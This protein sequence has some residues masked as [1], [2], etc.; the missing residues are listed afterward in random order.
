MVVIVHGF[1][2]KINALQFEWSWQNPK[3]SKRLIFAFV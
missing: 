1:P 3:K 2:S